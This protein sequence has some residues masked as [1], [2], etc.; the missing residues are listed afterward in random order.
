MSTQKSFQWDRP[1]QKSFPK[2][3]MNLNFGYVCK[4]RACKFML[5]ASVKLYRIIW[6]IFEIF[7]TFQRMRISSLQQVTQAKLSSSPVHATLDAG[8]DS[9]HPIVMITCAKISS[10]CLEQLFRSDW[11]HS[12]GY[13]VDFANKIKFDTEQSILLLNFCQHSEDTCCMNLV[14]IFWNL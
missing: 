3:Y 12:K 14:L 6:N 11:S 1:L 7:G 9:E 10:K 4:I 5:N 8:Q 2:K 13:C